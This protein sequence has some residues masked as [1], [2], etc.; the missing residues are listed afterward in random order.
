[1]LHITYILAHS[2]ST[3]HTFYVH[4]RPIFSNVFFSFP[5]TNHWVLLS[6]FV[7]AVWIS[8]LSLADSVN[9]IYLFHLKHMLSSFHFW[10]FFI[11]TNWNG[12]SLKSESK[13]QRLSLNYSMFENSSRLK[14]LLFRFS[15]TFRNY[16]VIL[17]N[18]KYFCQKKPVMTV[19]SKLSWKVTKQMGSLGGSVG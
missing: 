9:E 2:F 14:T 18:I 19:N 12:S 1:M 15:D 6:F 7:V 16:H 4:T 5:L 17:N 13:C 3:T 11:P 10:N 8:I